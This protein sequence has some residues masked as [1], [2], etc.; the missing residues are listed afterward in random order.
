LL[1]SEAIRV[2]DALGH[3]ELESHS[4]N[5]LLEPGNSSLE[6]SGVVGGLDGSDGGLLT[7][8]DDNGGGET[9]SQ[10]LI[11]LIAGAGAGGR[12]GGAG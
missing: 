6:V 10:R 5:E 9:S 8:T 11:T 3:L 4:V 7:D 1:L 12:V 2:G